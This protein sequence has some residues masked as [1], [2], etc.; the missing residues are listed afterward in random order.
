MKR[1][2]QVYLKQAQRKVLTTGVL[3][4]GV[5][6]SLTSFAQIVHAQ[7]S[8]GDTIGPDEKVI[9]TEDLACD[10]STG[11]LTVRGPATIDL[12]GFTVTCEDSDQNGVV[13]HGIFALGQKVKLRN[14]SIVGCDI[15]VWLLGSGRHQVRDITAESNRIGFKSDSNANT[16]TASKALNNQDEGFGVSRSR[17]KLRNN[18]AYGNGTVG[19]FVVGERHQLIANSASR[20][21]LHGFFLS[22]EKSRALRNTSDSNLQNGFMILGRNITLLKNTASGNSK[23]GIIVTGDENRLLRNMVTENGTAGIHVWAGA[24]ANRLDRNVGFDNDT[25]DDFSLH[26][27]L[28]DANPDCG[29]NKWRKNEGTTNQECVVPDA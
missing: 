20:N 10:D 19:F 25:A 11:G 8:C 5:A 15:G 28:E 21:T 3:M 1:T 17:T 4:L 12:N 27:D 24:D 23:G 2:L 16:L 29:T 26:F 22:S 14:G 18:E 6:L 9:F 7:V 13:P